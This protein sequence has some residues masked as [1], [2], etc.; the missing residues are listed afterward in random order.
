MKILV[1]L[2]DGG[3]STEMIELVKALGP[4]YEY[5]YMILITD[6]VSE[7]MIVWPGPIYRVRRPI[8]KGQL[9]HGLVRA[10]FHRNLFTMIYATIQQVFVWFKVRP[11][12]ILSTGAVVAVPVSVFGKLMGTKIIH[13]ETGARV[14]A[15]SLTGKLMYR[16]ADMFFVQWESLVENYPKAIYAGRLM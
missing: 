3:H 16:F 11:R 9:D 2:G 5:S 10:I 13:V 14:F 7:G 6:F 1:V 15:L 8:S 12:V 4:H